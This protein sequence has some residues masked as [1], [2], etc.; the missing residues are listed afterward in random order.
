MENAKGVVWQASEV[1]LFGFYRVTK[2]LRRNFEQNSINSLA[3]EI[4]GV[5]AVRLAEAP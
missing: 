2:L 1:L 4:P 5:Q 3:N